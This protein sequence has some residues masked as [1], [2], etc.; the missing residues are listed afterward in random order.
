MI[1]RT[2]CRLQ[3][4]FRRGLH[5]GIIGVLPSLIGGML[6]QQA[7]YCA[8]S[9]RALE[10][11]SIH[12]LQVAH[13]IQVASALS[14]VVVNGRM[15]FD[16]GAEETQW[17]EFLGPHG[18]SHADAPDLPVTWSEQEHVSWK[19]PIHDRGWSSPVIWDEQIWMGT[20]TGDGKRFY[21]VCVD[22]STGQVQWDLELFREEN[23]RF[24]HDM[25]SYASPTPAIE[26]G[27]VYLHFGSYGTACVDTETGQTVWS[28]RDLPCD[29]FRGP[30]S[31]PILYGDTLIIHFDGADYQYVVALDKAT[32]KTV[33]RSDRK[34]DYGTDNGDFKKAYSTP[35]I[36]RVGD[37]DQLISA[38]S[39]ACLALDPRDGKEIWRIRYDEFSVTARPLV[40]GDRL[41]VNTGFGKATL[42]CVR[43]TG[44]G[45]VTDSHVDW[46][47]RRN[48]GSKPSQV[49]VD[50]LIFGV[51]DEGVA[52]CIDLEDGSTV[53]THRF[54]GRYSSSPLFSG[55]YVYFFSHDGLTTVI[56]PSR[57]FKIIATNKLDDGFMASPAVSGNSLFV[58]TRT[59]L[60]RLE[61][62]PGRSN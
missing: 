13:G 19:T 61:N 22:K 16:D 26:A 37:R 40:A 23:P 17:P 2:L 25:N 8:A 48:V 32:G 44:T 9:Q 11:Q 1:S 31:S 24:C 36:I 18:N 53:W 60:Y 51:T 58:R 42:I 56:E 7:S 38:T 59:H 39:K 46:I 15:P 33:W 6:V 3:R 62:Q 10:Q 57:D 14:R 34:I 4:H 47:A 35:T 12:G 20:A 49:V 41:L 29:H 27:R 30:G 54:E 28:R 55:R 21:G 5:V 45:D 50:S 52:T 43:P